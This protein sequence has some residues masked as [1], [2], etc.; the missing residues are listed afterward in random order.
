MQ[1]ETLNPPPG[2]VAPSDCGPLRRDRS[3]VRA[4]F[5]WWPGPWEKMLARVFGELKRAE[6]IWAAPFWNL[7][8]VLCFVMW[9]EGREHR[10][11]DRIGESALSVMAR[12]R[13]PHP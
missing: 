5:Y 2:A 1:P 12:I 11:V 13:L 7:G 8:N 9:P 6:Q 4:D 3:P 10:R